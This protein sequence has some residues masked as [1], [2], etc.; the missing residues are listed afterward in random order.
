MVRQTVGS[1]NCAR[2]EGSVYRVSAAPR[3]NQLIISMSVSFGV[4]ALAVLLTVVAIVDDADAQI[5]S[6]G[7]C[8]VYEPMLGF[9]RERFMGTWHEVQRYFTVTELAARCISATYEKHPDDSLWVNN[10]V[11]NRL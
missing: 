6:F 2:V 10:A 5:P 9:D 3:K 11:T 4:I 8:P 7:G 1:F